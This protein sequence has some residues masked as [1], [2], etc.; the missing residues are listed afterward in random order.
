M[1]SRGLRVGLI[2]TCLALSA[3]L[4]GSA[5]FAASDEVVLP[6]G[7]V[8]VGAPG[9][10]RVWSARTEACSGLTGHFSSVKWYIVPDV[11]TFETDQGPEVAMWISGRTGDRIVIAGDYQ[12]SEMVVRHELLH[13]LLRHPGHPAEYFVSRCHLTWD[14]WDSAQGR[15]SSGTAE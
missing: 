14:S 2:G 10:Y 3:A 15:L 11:K 8:P 7:A 9:A 13:H 4:F 12:N 1:T 5:A 6:S